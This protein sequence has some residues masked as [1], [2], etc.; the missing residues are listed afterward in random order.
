MRVSKAG[1]FL[2][3]LM[4]P[5]SACVERFYPEEEAVRQGSLVVDA[6]LSD[7]PGEQ[8]IYISRAD[9][10]YYPE[11]QPESNCMVSVENQDG[12]LILFQET[13]AGNY[14]G[15]VDTSFIR[16]G[17][18]YR[19]H[20]VTSDGSIYES[21]YTRLIAS[22]PLD[23]VYYE[24]ESTQG[25][26]TEQGADA[27]G[28]YM[29]TRVDPENSPYK[30]WELVECYEFHNPDYQTF[31][32]DVDRRVKPTPEDMVFSVCWITSH[33]N[34][35][36]TQD[37][38]QLDQGL[39]FHKPLIQ[40]TNQSQ[41]L[42]HGYSLL[43]RQISLDEPAFRF[44]EALKGNSQEMTGMFDRQPSLTRSNI[45]NVDDP[46]EIILGYFSVSGVSEKRIFVSEVE[47]LYLPDLPFCV[48]AYE[49]PRLRYISSSDLPIFLAER[50]TEDLT[51][52]NEIPRKCVDCRLYPHSSAKPPDF[53]KKY[54]I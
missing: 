33:V 24:L 12:D 32:Y 10:L 11:Y 35:I 13:E 22:T 20:L 27:L 5:V 46:E 34:Q 49:P 4:I 7:L 36:M 42:V 38:G 30:R 44:W 40:V 6:D 52:N 18:Q 26:D 15:Q 54:S 31:I 48:P 8:S 50:E 37:Q 47:G 41:R 45:C 29:D 19:L 43:V 51:S 3:V 16:E 21:E 23:S 9:Q 39:L 17:M 25:A 53:W 1:R 14:V 28:F 2:L